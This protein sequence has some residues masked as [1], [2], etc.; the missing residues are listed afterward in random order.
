M[1]RRLLLDP[2]RPQRVAALAVAALLAALAVLALPRRGE[3]AAPARRGPIVIYLVDTLRFDRMS[4]YGARRDTT[5]AARR[6]VQEGVRYDT[7]YSVCTWTRPAVAAL[8]T[9]RLPAEVGAVERGGVLSPGTATVAELFRDAGWRTASFCGNPNIFSPGLGF[10]RGF[11]AFFGAK[12]PGAELPPGDL[13]VGPAAAWVDAQ[14]NPDFFLFVHV[15]DPHAPYD[16]FAPGYRKRYSSSLPPNATD[17][18]RTLAQYDGLVRQA[19]DQFARLRAVLE[20]K[21]FWNGALVVYLADHGE[22]FFEHGGQF[23]GDT[24]F[25]ETLRVPL[26]V[27]GPGWGSPGRVVKTPVSLLDVV[28][29]LA[30]WAGLPARSEWRGRAI[31]RREPDEDRELYYSEELDGA[32]LY[33]LRRGTRKAIVS[34][35]PPFRIEFDLS[36]DPGEQSPR[37]ASGDLARRLERLRASEIARYGGLWIH[38]T[39]TAPIRILGSVTG[40]DPEAP[41][42]LWSDRGRFPDDLASPETLALDR[43]LSRGEAFDLHV[44]RFGYGSTV[45]SARISVEQNGNRRPVAENATGAG[46]VEVVRRPMTPLSDA[47]QADIVKKMRALGYLGGN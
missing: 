2:A 21:G 3:T 44:T 14:P 31:D 47:E 23:H 24:L 13:V 4:A 32:R 41:F 11:D 18:D 27:K 26:I 39:G 17:R 12:A 5:P 34:L 20:R 40:L 25:E 45:P 36:S 22:Q 46:P 35:N 19:D 37:D 43:S 10:E 9:S 28:P 16:H 1:T 38:R 29:S 8:W 6:L 33:G 7:A 30:D 42:L 15:V